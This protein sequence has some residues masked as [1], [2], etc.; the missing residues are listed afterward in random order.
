M[1]VIMRL[2]AHFNFAFSILRHL[3][4]YVYAITSPFTHKNTHIQYI[5]KSLYMFELPVALSLPHFCTF[6]T[7]S[8]CSRHKMLGLR[9]KSCFE[10]HLHQQHIAANK[11]THPPT[12]SHVHIHRHNCIKFL[13]CY[14]KYTTAMLN[15]LLEA[16]SF[17]NYAFQFAFVVS[18]GGALWRWATL[19]YAKWVNTLEK[20]IL[21]CIY[22][23]I[24]IV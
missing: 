23:Y 11:Y 1:Y 6:V 17:V 5:S 22:I 13:H 7:L 3:Y 14:A 8:Q 15:C 20:H 10:Q 9:V 12:H 21:L 16:V 24:E 18:V 4:T 2:W 19:K